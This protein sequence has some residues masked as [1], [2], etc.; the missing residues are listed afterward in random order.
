MVGRL[1]DGLLAVAVRLG[2]TA[3]LHHHVLAH[4]MEEQELVCQLGKEKQH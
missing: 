2:A 1:G 3:V 4:W